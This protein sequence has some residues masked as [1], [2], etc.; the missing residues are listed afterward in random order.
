MPKI[1]QKNEGIIVELALSSI[2]ALTGFGFGV[3]FEVYIHT[4]K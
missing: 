1:A 2:K 3:T 4:N